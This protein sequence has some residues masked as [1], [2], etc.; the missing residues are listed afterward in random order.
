MTTYDVYSK[1]GADRRFASRGD[2][3]ALTGA[4]IAQGAE[5]GTLKEQVRA[6]LL[7][8]NM[9]PRQGGPGV[10]TA[11]VVGC[12]GDSWMTPGAGGPGGAPE[13][14]TMPQIAAKRL[15]VAAAISGQGS[16]GWAHVH[17]PQGTTGFFSAPARVDAVLDAHPSLLVVV[18]SVNDNWT[19]DQPPT[20]A[21]P[22][23]GPKAI[24]D[25]VTSLVARVRDRAP[26]LPI[27]VV[28]PK[29]TSE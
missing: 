17:S 1:A 14:A 19:I 12:I 13:E 27:I 24:K 3:S 9:L 15:G 22:A 8:S 20:P 25:S 21:D 29:T 10:P 2:V 28:G 7:L 5:I 4:Q 26:A 11:L 6:Q 16:T 18:G 23:S